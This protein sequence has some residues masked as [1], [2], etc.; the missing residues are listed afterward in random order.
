MLLADEI[1]RAPRGSRA[2]LQAMQERQVTLGGATFALPT[3]F[4]VLATQDPS[5]GAGTF[6]FPASPL[7]RFML[8]HRVTLPTELEEFR[9]VDQGCGWGDTAT[10]TE[11]DVIHE[12]PAV[13]PATLAETFRG[14]GRWRC[15]RAW[16]C[17]T[18]GWR[19]RP[20]PPAGKR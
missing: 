1:N 11:F 9:M 8:C 10:R 12:K 2:P 14:C 15:R 5:E 7:D 3:P 6:E 20:G 4:L 16:S 19:N 17:V 18:S 13:A